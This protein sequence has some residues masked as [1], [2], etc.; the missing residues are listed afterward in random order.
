MLCCAVLCCAVLCC[1]VLCCAV[2]YCT[3]LYCNLM[4]RIVSYRIVS[5][6]IVS[7]RINNVL[8]RFLTVSP[9]PHRSY[10]IQSFSTQPTPCSAWTTKSSCEAVISG[11]FH[12]TMS[13]GD[14]PQVR[15]SH[16]ILLD[17]FNCSISGL[18]QYWVIINHSSYKKLHRGN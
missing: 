3:V 15:L 7:Y 1:A 17:N 13:P 4:Y 2:L 5:Y 12:P 16:H 11:C 8:D 14:T 6:R 10:F 9:F 18:F